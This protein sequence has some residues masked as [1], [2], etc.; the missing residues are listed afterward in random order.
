MACL[1]SGPFRR[2][3]RTQLPPKPA[4]GFP[5]PANVHRTFVACLLILRPL[6]YLALHIPVSQNL[7]PQ[8]RGSEQVTN[9][10]LRLTVQKRP[11]TARMETPAPGR[12][13]SVVLVLLSLAVLHTSKAQK[14]TSVRPVCV[15][16]SVNG[17]SE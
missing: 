13:H 2:G 17:A 14:V 15:H 1:D 10:A 5:S 6:W 7:P 8:G 16:P 11:A 3:A 12:T 9:S 4:P